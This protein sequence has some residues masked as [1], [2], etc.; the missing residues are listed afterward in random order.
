MAESVQTRSM[1]HSLEP[2]TDGDGI[3]DNKD[4]CP[5]TPGTKAN[6]GCPEGIKPPAK[7]FRYDRDQDGVPNE[8]DKCPDIAGTEEDEGCPH[9]PAKDLKFNLNAPQKQLELAAPPRMAVVQRVEQPIEAFADDPSRDADHDG[10]RNG[11]DACPF[12]PAIGSADGCP[13]LT[14]SDLELL[15]SLRQELVF[16]TIE[17]KLSSRSKEALQSLAAM[18]NVQY[19]TAFVTFSVYADEYIGYQDNANLCMERAAEIGRFLT[20]KGVE[21]DRLRFQ[22]FANLRSFG[23]WR[24]EERSKVEVEVGFR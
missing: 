4:A 5:D 11:R 7:Q 20:E 17:T 10:I 12:S 9:D 1:P 23:A 3:P 13:S 24:A 16:S 18:L 19:P 14:P 22:Y 8:F 6:K 21:K 15:A 2:D